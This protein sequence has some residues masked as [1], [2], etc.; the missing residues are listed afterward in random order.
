MKKKAIFIVLFVLFH[1]VVSLAC[2]CGLLENLRGKVEE[3]KEPAVVNPAD[4]VEQE[5]AEDIP[6]IE[7][8]EPLKIEEPEEIVEPEEEVIQ[9][10][11]DLATLQENFGVE[12]DD[13][14]VGFVMK[15]L[16]TDLSLT[17][18]EY[19][20]NIM[21]GDGIIVG[22]ENNRFPWLLPQ[23]T[24]GIFY[25]VSLDEENPPVESYNIV[26]EFEDTSQPELSQDPFTSEKIKLWESGYW[27]IATGIVKN[28][29]TNIYTDVRTSVL[30]Y[31]A[32]G[33]IVGGG[34][35]YM[36]FIPGQ[37][38]MGFATYLDIYDAVDSIEVFPILT[39]MSDPYEDSPELW[40]M[41]SVADEYYYLSDSDDI[42]GGTVVQSTLADKT[43][44]D[45]T[46]NITFYD[47]EGYV[48]SHGSQYID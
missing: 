25:R 26:L 11:G 19:T 14:Y 10:V 23:Q 17:D 4:I 46:L 44:K 18:V 42:Y 33:K 6:V 31:D 2:T 22:Q 38:Q 30:C 3:A 35:E 24:L 9:A 34:Y 5:P 8:P 12:E 45:V 36:D 21:D 16:N 48:I 39:Y 41:T 20:I 37:G 28:G 1:L 13:A 43:L 7:E 15:N 47:D 40:G 29:D 27:P 32:D